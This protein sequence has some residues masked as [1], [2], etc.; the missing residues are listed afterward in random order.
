MRACE[1]NAV[2]QHAG[3][4]RDRLFVRG[5]RLQ[6]ADH[7][8][9]FRGAE[10]GLLPQDDGACGEGAA[11]REAVEERGGRGGVGGR[12]VAYSEGAEAAAG[13]LQREGAV[14][15]DQPR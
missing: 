8:R 14:P 7:A 13:V 6:L 5:H 4:D 2:E 9:A 3:D 10:H 1:E 12:L 15:V 11:R